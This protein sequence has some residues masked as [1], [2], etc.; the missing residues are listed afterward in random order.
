MGLSEEDIDRIAQRMADIVAERLRRKYR[1]R[2][3][4]WLGAR[5]QLRPM[6]PLARL[7]C[8]RCFEDFSSL[9]FRDSG[10]ALAEGVPDVRRMQ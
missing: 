5:E 9:E 1:C 7:H 2:R 4:G 6:L 10:F 8:P 3:C